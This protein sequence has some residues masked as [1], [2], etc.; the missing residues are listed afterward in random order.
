M[1]TADHSCMQISIKRS[2]EV[3]EFH[4]NIK[5]V[6]LMQYVLLWD[7]TYRLIFKTTSFGWRKRAR[8]GF[9][10]CVV[11]IA[12]VICH[13]NVKVNAREKDIDK[14]YVKNTFYAILEYHS[15]C[16]Y[17]LNVHFWR[18]LIMVYLVGSKLCEVWKDYGPYLKKETGNGWFSRQ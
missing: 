18:Y 15:F 8:G 6:I 12:V 1:F 13:Q 3:R 9:R 10:N 7:R 14:W 2:H 17:S 4:G 5:F 11:T 16:F